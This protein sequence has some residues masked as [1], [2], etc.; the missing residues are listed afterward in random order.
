MAKDINRVE[1]M[2]TGTFTPGGAAAGRKITITGVEL[3]EMVE[4]F[5]QLVPVGGFTPVLKLGHAEAQ[6]FIGQTSGAPNLG[7]VAKIFREGEKVLANFSNVP[8]A[9]INLIKQ[10]RFTNVSVEIVPK[11]DFDGKTFSQVLTAVALLGAELP[12]VKGLAELSAAV[13]TQANVVPLEGEQTVVTFEQEIQDMSETKLTQEQHESLLEA[14]VSKAVAATKAEFADE[15]EKLTAERDEARDAVKT[16]TED[17]AAH[18][19]AV[20]VAEATT[21]VEKAIADGKLLPKQKDAALAFATNLSGTVKFGDEDKSM[22]AM[23]AD[24]LGQMPSKVTL[25]E[26]GAGST[27]E[28]D[29]TEYADASAE[30]DTKAREAM[31]ANDKLTYADARTLVLNGDADLKAAYSLA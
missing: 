11:M 18:V 24:F 22:T 28:G 3:D 21:M 26:K 19:K 20:S 8:D 14:A 1:I 30:V 15:T 16:V 12:A 7:I 29:V 23:F 4:S 17:Y 5:E 25:D 27:K 31:T 13:F 6:K 2:R 10:K 9:V